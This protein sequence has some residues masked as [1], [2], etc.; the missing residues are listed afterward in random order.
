MKTAFVNDGQ[1]LGAWTKKDGSEITK[2]A[3]SDVA[4][5]DLD[6]GKGIA[7]GLT[8]RE[9]VGTAANKVRVFLLTYLEFVNGAAVKLNAQLYV[10]KWGTENE[11][12]YW[13]T[14]VPAPRKEPESAALKTALTAHLAGLVDKE[15]PA[16]LGVSG[17]TIHGFTLESMSQDKK[18]FNVMFHIEQAAGGIKKVYSVVCLTGTDPYAFTTEKV[19]T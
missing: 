17:D 9:T 13:L 3:D 7:G 12:A 11:E 2:A 14:K 1:V 8:L 16:A 18:C 10:L 19:V 5:A 4:D 15:P 6:D